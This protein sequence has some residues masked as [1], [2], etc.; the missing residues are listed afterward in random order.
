MLVGR[1]RL[2]TVTVSGDAMHVMGPFLGQG[3]CSA[4]EDAVVLGRCLAQKIHD[5]P[6]LLRGTG[7]FMQRRVG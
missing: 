5:H 6:D 7:L 3:T 4:F 2:E 1:F